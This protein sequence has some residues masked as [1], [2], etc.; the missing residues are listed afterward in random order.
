MAKKKK[1][2][3]ISLAFV[4]ISI[5]F[6]SI[7][8]YHVYQEVM[9][10]E[11]LNGTQ[12]VI[13]EPSNTLPPL[14]KGKTDW[15]NWRGPGLDGK[16]M[17]SGIR[18]DWTGGLKKIWQVDY[19]CQGKQTATWS[20]VVVQGNRLVVPG[21]D[22]Q[23][24]LLFCLNS[25]NGDLIWAGSYPAETD[26]G[27]GPGPRA[28]PFIDDT[29]IYTF[30]RGGDLVCWQLYD[31][32]M[33]WQQ[34]VQSLGGMEPGWGYSSSPLV[35]KNLVIVQGGGTATVI[36]Y[37]KITGDLVWKSLEGPAGYAAL[38][39]GKSITDT[40]LIVFHG[41]GLSCLNPMTGQELWST[42]WETSY[43]VNATTPAISNNI[44][45]MTSGYDRGSQSLRIGE[46]SF[47][48]IWKQDNYASQHSDPVIIDGYIY[49][50]SGQSNQN[51]GDFVCLNLE[52]GLEM[53]RTNKIGWGTTVMVDGYLLC[54][55]IKGNL[56]LVNPDPSA[57]HK[58]TEMKNALTGKV[59]HPA[60]TIPVIAN[61]KLYLRYLQ[62]LICYDLEMS[63]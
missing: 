63:E 51:R 22:E 39:L 21:R 20:S 58:V 11:D 52:T 27:H 47:E 30:G 34:N 5:I 48:I 53:W 18:R 55:D 24:D 26:A 56:F 17:V 45:F 31:G 19:L 16:S 8:A 46:T 4:T 3:W 59:K 57:F 50:Y 38:T 12:T 37:D 32:E 61:G 54:M 44:L 60:W 29:L 33:V 28:T 23:N 1:W 25:E 7:I 14:V 49:G 36:A 10:S 62:Q 6:G 9:G 15:P 40:S 2:L 41:K 35:F 13:P 42:S 43:D